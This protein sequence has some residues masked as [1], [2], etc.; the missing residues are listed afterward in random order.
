MSLTTIVKK[1]H[2]HIRK[3]SLF[4]LLNEILMEYTYISFR[5]RYTPSIIKYLIFYTNFDY[6]PYSK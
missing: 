4:F 6:L 1:S 3:F 2:W 5:F